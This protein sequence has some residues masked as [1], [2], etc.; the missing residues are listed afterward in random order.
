[1]I[2]N[3]IVDLNEAS[4]EAWKR[5]RYLDKV[6]HPL[7][8]K[9]IMESE[10]RSLTLWQLWSM[11]ESAYKAHFRKDPRRRLNPLRL[12]CSLDNE[13]RGTVHVEASTYNT[14]TQIETDH[15]HTTATESGIAPEQI[16]SGIIL[17]NRSSYLRKEIIGRLKTAYAERMKISAGN[18]VFEKDQNYIPRMRLSSKDEGGR[19]LPGSLFNFNTFPCSI[20][21]HGEYGAYA[22]L[23]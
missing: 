22:F 16:Q 3:D 10:N 13:Q 15:L 5:K 21:H 4:H 23:S 8:Q 12:R 1:M 6:F 17:C 18:L 20:S 2:G 11:K 14:D 9:L 19:S 7:E